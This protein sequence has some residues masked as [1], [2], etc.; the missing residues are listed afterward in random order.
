MDAPEVYKDQSLPTIEPNS[1]H[2]RRLEACVHDKLR[3]YLGAEYQ[4]PS[5]AEYIVVML[6]HKTN[7]IAVRQALVEF[8]R[9]DGAQSFVNWCVLGFLP[10]LKPR[11]IC[12]FCSAGRRGG[13]TG[14]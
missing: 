4:D 11:G 3:Q 5:L 7:R 6:S 13:T 2:G 8:L 9:E 14:H 12:F 1:S 10:V